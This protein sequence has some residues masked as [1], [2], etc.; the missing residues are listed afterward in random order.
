[1]TFRRFSTRPDS[2]RRFSP[3]VHTLIQWQSSSVWPNG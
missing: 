3:S 1:L 2:T